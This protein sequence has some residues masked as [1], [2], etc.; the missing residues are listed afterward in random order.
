VVVDA[1]PKSTT[2]EDAQRS[3]RRSALINS[4]TE[5][6][7]LEISGKCVNRD[8]AFERDR[9]HQVGGG[10]GTS[11]CMTRRSTA[12]RVRGTVDARLDKLEAELAA[13]L[14]NPVVTRAAE[15]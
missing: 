7:L 2:N 13:L 10:Q 14:T 11:F 3:A 8:L 9:H 1:G 6:T 5:P 4:L 15:N 12:N